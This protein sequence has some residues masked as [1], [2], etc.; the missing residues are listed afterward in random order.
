MPSSKNILGR[1][2]RWDNLVVQALGS[3]VITAVGWLLAVLAQLEVW[4][5]PVFWAVFVIGVF[6]TIGVM[7]SSRG[8]NLD[9]S[10]EWLAPGDQDGGALLAGVISVTCTHA[11]TVAKDWAFS[12]TMPD[13]TSHAFGTW[14][15]FSKP[16]K[17]RMVD[18]RFLLVQRDATIA[19]RTHPS[20]A[21]G[22]QAVGFLIGT[23]KGLRKAAMLETGVKAT[24]ACTDAYRR[25]FTAE[26]KLPPEPYTNLPFHPSLEYKFEDAET[27]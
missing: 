3:V 8:P 6:V 12:V 24:V 18:G 10:F 22:A 9:L 15:D 5:D 17:I 1:T 2:F 23:C 19:Y 7:T 26:T 25:R 13:G 16:F 4:Q 14:N 11:A 27:G 20:V 21:A